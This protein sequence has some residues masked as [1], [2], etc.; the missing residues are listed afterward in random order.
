MVGTL[1][2]RC[3][4]S[5]SPVSTDAVE[6]K[7]PTLRKELLRQDYWDKARNTMI[8]EFALGKGKKVDGKIIPIPFDK[9]SKILE[10]AIKKPAPSEKRQYPGMIQAPQPVA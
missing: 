8:D 3:R 7:D 2:P 9:A 10:E 6:E 1:H 5:L 4:C